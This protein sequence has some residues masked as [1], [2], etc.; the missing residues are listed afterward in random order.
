MITAL[1]LFLA[2][3][4]FATSIVLLASTLLFTPG[5]PFSLQA[6]LELMNVSA[7]DLR[8]GKVPPAAQNPFAW[9][10]IPTPAANYLEREHI[11]AGRP[12]PLDGR[13]LYC[14][15]LLRVRSELLLGVLA[16]WLGIG[17][18]GRPL[19]YK[20]AMTAGLSAGA[21]FLG[22]AVLGF[23]QFRG[24]FATAARSRLESIRSALPFTID[25]LILILDAG[26]DFAG[27]IASY[28]AY[29]S[30][31]P[32]KNDLFLLL[33]EMR[34]GGSRVTALENLSRRA[35]IGEIQ[36]LV[37]VITQG[38]RAGT[39]IVDIL[40]KQS[41]LLRLERSQRAMAIAEQMAVDSR[42]WLGGITLA[43]LL[44]LAGPFIVSMVTGITSITSV[45]AR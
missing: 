45:T 37:L 43:L 28:L 6:L 39:P 17:F 9:L 16:I 40:R 30:E 1:V 34:A 10:R 42:G 8:K 38:E 3:T 29:G 27:A 33:Q 12:L 24:H 21:V 19:D 2:Q 25:F 31:G 14:W 7:G 35:P 32:L 20:L 11:R 5:T 23:I 22:L 26:G 4:V 13:G 36:R 44:L 18:A 15:A 41:E